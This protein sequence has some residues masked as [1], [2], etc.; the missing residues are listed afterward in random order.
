MAWIES[1][2]VL[3]RHR[4]L[5][6]FARELRL[7]PVYAMGH[8]HS[9]WHN[10]LEQAE[11]GDLS[12]WSDEFI[13]ESASYSGDAPK[14]VRLLQKHKWLDGKVI[15]DWLDCAGMYLT[16]KYSSS[17]REKLAEIWSKHRRCYG[18]NG[19]RTEAEQLVSL[20]ERTVPTYLPGEPGLSPPVPKASLSETIKLEKEL[21]RIVDE[22]KSCGTLSD[23]ATGS[24]RHNRIKELRA[25]Q[26]EI[27][28]TLGVVA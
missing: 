1:H 16:R 10:A 17:N 15:H 13:A 6:E 2:T 24:P 9:L 21:G 3:L 5:K 28:Q 4:K 11:D 12:A 14:F 19:K 20:P 8:L 27:R 26:G 25:R 7:S 23:Y 18:V 22:L